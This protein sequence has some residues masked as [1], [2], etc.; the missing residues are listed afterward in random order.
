MVNFSS[1]FIPNFATVSEPLRRLT[2]QNVKFQWNKEQD[3]A[4]EQ[5]KM[6]LSR[7]DVLGYFDKNAEKTQVIADAS[8]VALGSAYWYNVKNEYHAICYASRSLTDVEKDIHRPKR[9]PLALC[10][11]VRDLI[12]ISRHLI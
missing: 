2:R 4:F 6:L 10:G 11:H 5:L 1:K 7:A 12:S 3:Q 8:P 9:R